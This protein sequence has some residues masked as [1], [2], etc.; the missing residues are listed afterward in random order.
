MV[1]QGTARA[2]PSR[3]FEEV[4][5][6]PPLPRAQRR[7]PESARTGLPDQ[8]LDELVGVSPGAPV[9]Y[10]P[11]SWSGWF[12]TT[13]ARTGR[14]RC[15]SGPRRTEWTSSRVRRRRASWSPVECHAGDL[16]RLALPRETFTSVEEVRAA[17]DACVAYRNTERLGRGKRFRDTAR[18]D[19]RRKAK[20]PVWMPPS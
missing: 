17:L 2:D 4:R 16:Q 1:S 20:V 14:P 7:S 8:A 5:D 13:R 19:C 10:P 12:R 11:T 9:R 3:V 15:G 6:D 18:N